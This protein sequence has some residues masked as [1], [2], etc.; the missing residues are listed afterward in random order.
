[1]RRLP[2]NKQISTS[3][4]NVK[5]L[6][7]HFVVLKADLSIQTKIAKYYFSITFY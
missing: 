5:H 7:R 1:M 6:M 3:K 2:Q 4:D